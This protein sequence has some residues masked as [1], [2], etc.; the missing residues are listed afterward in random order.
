[1]YLGMRVDEALR[2]FLD[3][4]RLPGEAL[5]IERL[6]EALSRQVFLQSPGNMN[7]SSLGIHLDLTLTI[8][9]SQR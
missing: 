4:F 5:Q 6:M 3:T 9:F 7:I 2:A 1:M 8:A